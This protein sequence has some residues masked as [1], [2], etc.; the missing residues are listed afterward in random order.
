MDIILSKKLGKDIT[1]IIMTELWKE[2]FDFVVKEVKGIRYEINL[3]GSKTYI[4]KNFYISHMSS[5]SYIGMR[6]ISE[7]ISFND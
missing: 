6:T 4:N 5:M 2:R 1:E 3:C 7:V